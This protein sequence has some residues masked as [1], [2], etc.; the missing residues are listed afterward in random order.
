M[1]TKE[2]LVTL[3]KWRGQNA[4]NET[5]LTQKVWE[6]NKHREW[7]KDWEEKSKLDE[8]LNEDAEQ[9]TTDTEAPAKPMNEE[10]EKNA[11]V[12]EDDID[13]TDREAL[14]KIAADLN[15][16]YYKTI[17]T[18]KLADLIRDHLNS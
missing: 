1:R 11:E 8:E 12:N 10:V 4:G 15:V 14:K 9:A 3:V 7:A 18:E 5:I 13:W 16:E 6:D 2:N 17:K